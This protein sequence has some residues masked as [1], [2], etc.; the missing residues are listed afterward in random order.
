MAGGAAVVTVLSIAPLWLAGVSL[1]EY[2]EG[3]WI[4]VGHGGSRP[5]CAS[6]SPNRPWHEATLFPLLLLAAAF[7]GLCRPL[8]RGSVAWGAVA[9]WLVLDVAAALASCSF[10]PHQFK[11]VVPP[12]AV[13]AGIAIAFGLALVRARGWERR[14]TRPAVLALLAV[15]LAPPGILGPNPTG[16]PREPRGYHR[17][18]GLWLRE[19][20]EPGDLV[21]AWIGGGLVQALSER[22]SPSR[23]FNK[24][25]ATSN[26]A[27]QTVLRDLAARPPR[28]VVIDKT[29]PEWLHAYAAGCCRRAHQVEDLQIFESRP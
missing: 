27:V 26:G 19:H 25:F 22:A 15:I 16:P 14:W 5:Y 29:N 24:H 20:S 12:A 28:F 18:A 13:A 10:F 17:E 2:V 6:G 23:Y 4:I 11:Q 1:R 9:L 7:L 8:V 3:A 21:Y